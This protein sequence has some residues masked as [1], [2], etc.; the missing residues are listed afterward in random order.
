MSE[1]I[2]KR[3]GDRSYGRW[4]RDLDPY[5]QIPTYVMKTRNDASNFFSYSVDISIADRYLRQK[6]L[7]G[8][9]G[10]GYLHLFIATFI[11][12]VSQYPRL[13]R[14]VSGQRIYARDKIEVVMTI[15]KGMTSDDGETSI[16]MAFE[17]TDTIIDVYN[18]INNEIALVRNDNQETSTDDLAELINKLPRLTLKFTVWFLGVLDYFGLLPASIRNAS[19]FH[20]SMVI[21]DLGSLGIPPV[22]HHLYNFGDVPIFLAFGSKRKAYELNKEGTVTER[23]FIDFTASTDERICDGFYFAQAFKLMRNLMKNPAQLEET[24]EEVKVDLG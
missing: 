12:A 24:P 16:K 10:I 15:K 7:D 1:S 8:Y 19:P 2:K 11:R 3:R 13:N 5:Y 20:G 21:T 9:K 14:F 22:F 23:K 6:R 4:L 18:K 17:P